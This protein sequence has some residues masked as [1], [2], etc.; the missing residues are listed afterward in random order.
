[1]I[2]KIYDFILKIPNRMMFLSVFV[3]ITI[4]AI[5]FY[6]QTTVFS[7][8]LFVLLI[9][10]GLLVSMTIGPIMF[11]I[12]KDW[13]YEVIFFCSL[14]LTMLFLYFLGLRLDRREKTEEDINPSE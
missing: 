4:L 5:V 6:K 7:Y 11:L 14:I 12:S 10:A 1:M 13:H 2:D 3:I 8:I 9:P